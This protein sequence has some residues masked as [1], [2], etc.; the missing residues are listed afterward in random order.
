MHITR[1]SF[2]KYAKM[3]RL[4]A[5]AS[6]GACWSAEGYKNHEPKF[7]NRAGK[8]Y[9]KKRFKHRWDSLKQQYRGWMEPK[10]LTVIGSDPGRG[11]TGPMMRTPEHVKFHMGHGQ[12]DFVACSVQDRKCRR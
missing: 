9:V 1:R 6:L 2:A 11:I 12:L 4:L 3:K 10:S 5:I 8:R 7:Y